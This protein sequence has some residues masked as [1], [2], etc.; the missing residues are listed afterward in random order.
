MRYKIE[1]TLQKVKA[2]VPQTFAFCYILPFT[3]TLNGSF[4]VSRGYLLLC[5]GNEC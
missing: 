4:P 1:H 3:I 5:Y 2:W